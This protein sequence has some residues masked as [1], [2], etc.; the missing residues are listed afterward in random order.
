MGELKGKV[1]YTRGENQEL[2]KRFDEVKKMRLWSG[3][4][5]CKALK[6]EEV[7]MMIKLWR[8]E[9][10][11]P[12]ELCADDVSELVNFA[13]RIKE[14]RRCIRKSQSRLRQMRYREKLEAAAKL[15]DP[16]AIRKVENIKKAGRLRHDKRRKI[17]KTS[18]KKDK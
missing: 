16:E 1:R 7:D 6:D 18:R 2:D 11:T 8:K 13:E 4:A 12:S 14:Y 5:C 9:S 10:F 3:T 17:V 15:K